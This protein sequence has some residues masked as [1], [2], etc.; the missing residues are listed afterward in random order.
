MGAMRFCEV[1]KI[2]V[3][4]HFL[5]LLLQFTTL[6][7]V[8]S[9]DCYLTVLGLWLA[10]AFKKTLRFS[11]LKKGGTGI[12]VPQFIGEPLRSSLRGKSQIK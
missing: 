1:L 6:S 7:N 3:L 4:N 12:K 11:D 5:N 9:I 8:F 10:I 2:Q